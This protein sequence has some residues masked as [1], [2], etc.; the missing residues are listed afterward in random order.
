MYARVSF[1]TIYEGILEEAETLRFMHIRRFES[2]CVN[3]L[4]ECALFRMHTMEILKR[5]VAKDSFKI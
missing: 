2:C 1:H 5:R 4:P 3:F